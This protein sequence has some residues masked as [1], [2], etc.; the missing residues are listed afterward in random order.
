MY[1][2][3]EFARSQMSAPI[4]LV[5]HF[6]SFALHLSVWLQKYVATR[7][8]R[9]ILLREDN[10]KNVCTLET[11]YIRSR[12]FAEKFTILR[13]CKQTDKMSS[14]TVYA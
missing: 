14:L 4:S 11:H 1:K 8:R 9:D 13:M 6:S 10:T 7:R 2:K 12:R 5:V 3:E